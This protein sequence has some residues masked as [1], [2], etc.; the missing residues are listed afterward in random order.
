MWWL[1]VGLRVGFWLALI[2]PIG[3]TVE[4]L[5]PSSDD[6]SGFRGLLALPVIVG[7]VFVAV[8]V[9]QY[10]G[11]NT[12]LLGPA[13]LAFGAWLLLGKRERDSGTGE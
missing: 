6:A 2:A 9:C 4:K 13:Y 7:V 10:L 5:S 8:E 12:L 3:W 1:F 11:V